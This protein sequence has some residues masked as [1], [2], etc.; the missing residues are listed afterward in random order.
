MCGDFIKNATLSTATQK[1]R[2]DKINFII[3]Q[4]DDTKWLIT[5][6]QLLELGRGISL[7]TRWYSLGFDTGVH[8]V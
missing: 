5:I 8:H 3:F 1:R 7:M 4:P 6:T 2:T